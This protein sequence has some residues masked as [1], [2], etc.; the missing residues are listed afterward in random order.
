MLMQSS[1]IPSFFCRYI[2]MLAILNPEDDEARR[3]QGCHR[4]VKAAL[5]E[6]YNVSAHPPV[7]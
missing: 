4:A 6:K 5:P 3:C 7:F 1:R 2:S